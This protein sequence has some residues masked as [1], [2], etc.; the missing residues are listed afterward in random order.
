MPNAKLFDVSH[1]RWNKPIQRFVDEGADG[2]ICKATEGTSH[3]DGTYYW[4]RDECAKI[5][6]P[7]GSYH[8][9]RAAF[10]PVQQAKHYHRIAYGHIMRPAVDVESYNNGGYSKA[11][12]TL[13]L[14]TMLDTLETI[15]EVR[16]K[17]YTSWYMWTSL[18]TNPTWA[19]DYELWVAHYGAGEP[20]LPPRFVGW[21]LWQWTSSYMIDG[22]RYDANWFNGDN[23]AFSIYLENINPPV[24]I[25]IPP[26]EDIEVELPSKGVTMKLI[27]EYLD[28]PF[29]L[30]GFKSATG[31]GTQIITLS[32]IPEGAKGVLCRFA[33]RGNDVRNWASLGGKHDGT[34]RFGLDGRVFNDVSFDINT[35][36]IPLVDNKLYVNYDGHENEVV[37]YIEV[38][39]YGYEPTVPDELEERVDNLFLLFDALAS[40]IT[41]IQTKMKEFVTNVRLFVER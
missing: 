28:E 25:P 32:N 14:K 2:L 7:F 20:L 8:Y 33:V 22:V 17:I 15:W 1:W 30:Q 5:N 18:T 6:L 11:L 21:K 13:Y 34:R 12:F 9:F 41:E 35:G 4:Y 10:D 36:M 38:H 27:P 3:I 19:K 26:P 39:G 23:N 37:Y 40:K 29:T 16:P 31:R 24:P